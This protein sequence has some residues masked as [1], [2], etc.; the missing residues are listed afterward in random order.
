MLI[1]NFVILNFKIKD[2]CQMIG[3]SCVNKSI[4]TCALQKGSDQSAELFCLFDLMLYIHGKQLRSCL[5]GQLLNHTVPGQA[6]QG[7]FTSI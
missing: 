1:L 7:Q 2:Y 5:D 4:L 6:S 3:I